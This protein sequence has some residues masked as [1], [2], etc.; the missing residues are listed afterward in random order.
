MTFL[1]YATLLMEHFCGSSKR[2]PLHLV[3]S[4]RYLGMQLPL[5]TS[6]GCTT[7]LNVYLSIHIVGHQFDAR[8]LLPLLH[9]PLAGG[10][11]RL[12]G[13]DGPLQTLAALLHFTDLVSI[14]ST[15]YVRIF[16]TIVAFWQLFLVACTL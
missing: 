15:F 3:Q 4:T 5:C 8:P 1:P 2:N 9:L 7:G 12:L 16:H 6:P 13:R 14:S 11:W 10:Q